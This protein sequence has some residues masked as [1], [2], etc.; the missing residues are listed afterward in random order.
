MKI[1]T[2]L[3]LLG[4]FMA[5]SQAAAEDGVVMSSG[6]CP[7]HWSKFKGRCFR[8]FPTATS[9][10]RAERNCLSM[11]AHLASVHNFEEH[12]EIMR[13]INAAGRS[14]D[15]WIGGSDAEEEGFWLWSDGS[16]FQYTHWCSGEPNNYKK[17]QHCLQTHFGGSKCWDDVHCTELRPFVC[18]INL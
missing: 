16:Y 11:K 6:S 5:L 2:S 7:S 9:W 12:K 4:A 14:S 13:L 8:Y 15:V 1:W 18:A 3:L 17:N 10:A